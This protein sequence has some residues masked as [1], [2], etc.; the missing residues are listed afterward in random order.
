MLLFKDKM[1]WKYPKGDGF[2]AHQDHPAWNDF[3]I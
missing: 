3:N 2:K 1:N